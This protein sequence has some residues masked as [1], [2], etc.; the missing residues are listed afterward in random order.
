MNAAAV[1][2]AECP[3]CGAPLDFDD[4]ARAIRC[5]HCRSQL[6]VTGRRQVLTYEIE[7]RISESDARSLVRFALPADRQSTHVAP[8]R[9][10]LVPYYRFTAEEIRWESADS[11]RQRRRNVAEVAGMLGVAVPGTARLEDRIDPDEGADFSSRVIERNFVA[12]KT[13]A[14]PHSLGVRPAALQLRLF[15]RPEDDD[16]VVVVAADLTPREAQERAVSVAD[17]DT[18]S[19]ELLRA[20]LQIVYF[21]FWMVPTSGDGGDEVTV[22]DA[23]ASAIVNEGVEPAAVEAL[24]MGRR[25]KARTVGFRPLACP[26][27]GWDLPFRPDDLLFQCSSCERGWLA[28]GDRLEPIAFS[29]GHGSGD[30]AC[31]LPVW[32]LGGGDA[33]A[34]YAPAF[35]CRRLKAL[36]D[37]GA[38]LTRK[39]TTVVRAADVPTELV[40]CALDELDA[41]ALSRFIAAGIAEEASRGAV[42]PDFPENLDALSAELLWLPFTSD[43]YALREPMTGAPVPTRLLDLAS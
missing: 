20:V 16:R 31:H 25:R 28:R 43:G 6:L 42:R 15:D 12:R 38:R 4:D 7:S 2:S 19:R 13:A 40:G 34:V 37:L 41:R 26:N 36:Y 18:H 33:P 9:L 29:V 35:R 21:P 23:V 17:S 3:T 32:K 30:I 11:E 10:H 5:G 39:A 14:V 27:C 22:V 24:A 1:V 8:G